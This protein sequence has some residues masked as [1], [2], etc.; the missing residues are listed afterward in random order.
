M[1]AF[2]G[3]VRL[4]DPECASGTDRVAEIAR[5]LAGV[6][7]VVNVQGDEPELPG[8]SIDRVIELL[9][10]NPNMV[11]STLATPIRRREVLEDPSC[12]K[13][14]F[15]DRGRALYFSRSAIPHAREWRD[16]LLTTDPPHFYLHIGLYAYRRDFL[17][18]LAG[19]P[20]AAR[21]TGKSGAAS[22]AGARST[23]CSGSGARPNRGYRHARGLPGICQPVAQA[24]GCGSRDWMALALPVEHPARASVPLRPSPKYPVASRARLSGAGYSISGVHA[25]E[26]L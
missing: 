26:F 14:V 12:V 3:E 5:S 9:E 11:M 21:K 6:D 1:R 25:N 19:L 4:T 2:G 15:D 16:E 20:H 10:E 23:D 8:E 24:L 13:V 18:S 22:R 7:I 17:L